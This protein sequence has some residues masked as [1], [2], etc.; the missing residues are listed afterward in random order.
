MQAGRPEEEPGKTSAPADC[1][2][3]V[4]HGGRRPGSAPP[5]SPSSKRAYERVSVPALVVEGSY[6]KLLPPGWAKEIADQI[7]R[8]RSAV[9]GAAGHCP[10]IEQSAI[11]NALLMEFL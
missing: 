11:V 5:P 2:H 10:Q 7:P 8:G 6:D 9:V 1:D 4:G 3:T